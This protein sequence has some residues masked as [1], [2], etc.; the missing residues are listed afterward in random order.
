MI[1]RFALFCLSEA[2]FL[3][4]LEHPKSRRMEEGK[5][6]KHKFRKKN[7]SHPSSH[8]CRRVHLFSVPKRGK[9]HKVQKGQGERKEGKFSWKSWGRGGETQLL[10]L[11]LSKVENGIYF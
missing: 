5:K 2:L 9:G 8:C 1:F 7:P 11:C 6:S 4:Y 3:S 10:S